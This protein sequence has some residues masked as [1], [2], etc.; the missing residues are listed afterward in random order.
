MKEMHYEELEIKTTATT[1]KRKLQAKQLFSRALV[2]QLSS[3]LSTLKENS[4]Q[5]R[6]HGESNTSEISIL[7]EEVK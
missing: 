6:L 7:Q 4:S 2:Q 5:H 3:I 1:T